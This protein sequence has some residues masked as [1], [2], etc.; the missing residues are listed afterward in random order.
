MTNLAQPDRIREERERLGFSQMAFAALAEASK[1][2]QIGWEQSRSSPN[3]EV[4]AAWAKAGADVLYIVT[5][6]RA[7]IRLPADEAELLA[8]YRAAPLAVKLAAVG[9]LEG[10]LK[11]K[12]GKDAP[13]QPPPDG[14]GPNQIIHG[15]VAGDN[16]GRDIIKTKDGD[17]Q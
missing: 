11:M 14:G 4:L 5:G 6:E 7:G 3:I 16:A 13:S 1:R 9:A 8:L 12:L 2:A 10:G 15:N 17:R